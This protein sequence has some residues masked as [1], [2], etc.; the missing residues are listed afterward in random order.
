[1]EIVQSILTKNP[2]Y[3]SGQKIAVKGLM[4]HSVGCP[5]PSAKTFVANWNNPSASRACVHAF[6]DG[7][8]GA[9]Y[10]TLPWNHKAWHCGG[11]GNSSHI[12]VEM[13]EPSCIRYT[14][15]S[16]FSCSDREKA[17]EV[18]DRTYKAA[19][20]LFADLCKQFGLNPH[21]DGVII[22]HAEGHKRGVASGHGDPEHLW[23]GMKCGY[24]MDTFRRDV[25]NAISGVA[26]VPVPAPVP[27]EPSDIKTGDIVSLTSNAVYYNGKEMPDWVKKDQWIVKSVSGDRVIIDQNVVKSHSISSPVAAKYL[28][29]V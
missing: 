18:V 3:Q 22:S 11:S 28:R 14:G 27:S 19:V 5:Q 12:G 21:A 7:N 15:G 25:Q 6:I 24:T 17:M 1:M 23:R 4:L 29:K 20:E 2:C 16:S 13:C 26:P 8:S 10:Q 9:V